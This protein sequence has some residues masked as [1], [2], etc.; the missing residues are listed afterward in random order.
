MI[1]GSSWLKWP[2]W[3]ISILAILLSWKDTTWLT[4]FFIDH[5]PMFTKFRDT[6]MML[7]LI[8]IRSRRGGDGIA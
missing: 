5:V 2:F 1:V 7:V 8:Q 4:D 3:V 6:K